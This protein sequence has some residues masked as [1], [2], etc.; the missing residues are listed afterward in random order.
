MQFSKVVLPDP[1]GPTRMVVPGAAENSASREKP[2]GNFFETRTARLCSMGVAG[3][4][5]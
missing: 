4:F 3:E 1:D 5:T 2:A